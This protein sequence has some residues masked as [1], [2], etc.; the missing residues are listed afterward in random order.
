MRKTY[1]TGL[2]ASVVALGLIAASTEGAQASPLLAYASSG[3]I[4]NAV[5]VS[6]TPE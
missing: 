5:G 1:W 6:G 4:N 2:K 3:T